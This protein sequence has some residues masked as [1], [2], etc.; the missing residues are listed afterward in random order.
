MESN[1]NRIDVS[2]VDVSRIPSRNARED[3]RKLWYKFTL[4]RLS[5]VGLAL[6]LIIIAVAIF[7][8]TFAPYPDHI[9]AMVDFKN[10]CQA[11][12]WEHLCGTDQAGRDI[13]SWA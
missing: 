13:L 5:I 6:I 7:Y 10:A 12:S 11:P 9:G 1:V 3:I 4:N 2:R 8:K